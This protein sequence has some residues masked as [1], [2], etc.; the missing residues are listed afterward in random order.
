[1]VFLELI[2]SFQLLKKIY[3]TAAIKLR[4]PPLNLL[5]SPFDMNRVTSSETHASYKLHQLLMDL[6]QLLCHNMRMIAQVHIPIFDK[7]FLNK[8]HATNPV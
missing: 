5:H 7:V 1:M 3:I 6:K 8:M 2:Y 4:Y